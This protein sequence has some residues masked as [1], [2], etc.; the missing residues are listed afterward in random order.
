MKV[1]IDLGAYNGDSLEV[2]LKK[3]RNFD[4]FYAFEP[5]GKN[6][7]ILKDKFS[8]NNRVFLIN[9]AADIKT[10]KSKLYPGDEFGDLGASLCENK[11]NIFKDETELVDTVDISKF[12]RDNFKP[13][14][15]IILKMDIEGKEYDVFEKM[16]EDKSI[17]YI[18]RIFCEWHFDR[19]NIPKEKHDK[20]V[21]KLNKLGFFLIGDNEWDEFS[22]ISK[23]GLEKVN[24]Y[25]K[26]NILFTK[27][28]LK[29]SYPS[30]YYRLKRIKDFLCSG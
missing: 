7:K 18:D 23:K 12:I 17:Q 10:G 3:Y 9:A 24:F 11:T 29:R 8:K 20:M 2:A 22:L 28:Y 25:I 21:E 27:I 16:I 19:I 4:K 15:K 30:L 1:F 6:F 14:D 26:K 13:N 5:P